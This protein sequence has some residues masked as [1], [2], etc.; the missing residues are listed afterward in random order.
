MSASVVNTFSWRHRYLPLVRAV[1]HPDQICAMV[2]LT[3]HNLQT[4]SSLFP[5]LCKLTGVRTV[6]YTALIKKEILK[7]GSN[8]HNS[9]HMMV[10]FVSSHLLQELWVLSSMDLVLHSS[11]SWFRTSSWIKVLFSLEVDFDHCWKWDVPRLC[12]TM[13]GLQMISLVLR[14]HSAWW[15]AVL[16]AH[17]RPEFVL[18]PA[19]L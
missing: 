6:S 4:G 17:F 5:N 9:V 18:I 12:L 15:I 2:P 7:K 3:P 10:L 1:L 13:Q 11:F 14:E 8:C 16:A 19:S